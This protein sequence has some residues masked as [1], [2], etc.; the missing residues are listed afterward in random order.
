MGMIANQALIDLICKL[1]Q[2]ARLK[3]QQKETAK[4]EKQ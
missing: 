2:R 3:K 1:R 4:K